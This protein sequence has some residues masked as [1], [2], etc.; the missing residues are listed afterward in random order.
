VRYSGTEALARV[1]VEA[2]SEEKMQAL[3]AG[4]AGRFRGLSDC[5]RI[6]SRASLGWTAEGGCPHMSMGGGGSSWAEPALSLSKGV[7]APHVDLHP[8]RR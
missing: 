2:E 8:W 6:P 4:I 5:E 3:T 1:M 7:P